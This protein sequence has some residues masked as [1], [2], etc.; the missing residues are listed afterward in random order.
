MTSVQDCG[1]SGWVGSDMAMA[2]PVK[3]GALFHS[4][5]A[6]GV[7]HGGQHLLGEGVFLP[8]P[9]PGE[10]GGRQRGQRH[11]LVD[12]LEDRPSALARVLNVALEAFQ[13]R[14]LLQELRGQLQQ[15]GAYHAPV[16]PEIGDP[17][18]VE[19]VLALG[20]QL[21]AFG[22]ALHH[23][24]LDTVVNHL[25]VVARAVAAHVGPAVRGREGLEDRRELVHDL[26]LAAYHE[27]VTDLEPPDAAARAGVHVMEALFLELGGAPHVVVE[28]GVAAVNDDIAG[29]QQGSHFVDGLFGRG[30]GGDHDPDGAGRFQLGDHVLERGG[31]DAAHLFRLFDEIRRPVV[32][33][34]AVLALLE[35]GDH[36]HAHLPEANESE[37]HRMPPFPVPSG[38]LW[39]AK[40]ADYRPTL[41]PTQKTGPL[42]LNSLDSFR[43]VG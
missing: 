14:V 34:H 35:A 40:Q 31:P 39:L 26:L 12:R 15:P 4:V 10:E 36:V 29:G 22:I 21:E 3:L 13:L 16:H 43:E 8:G 23:A 38:A 11:G 20:H 6:E 24:V 33:D 1:T 18:K 5:A 42:A 27:A 7:A 25:D 19:R 32:G 28:V 9:E 37:F 2:F 41:G 30:A 17:G